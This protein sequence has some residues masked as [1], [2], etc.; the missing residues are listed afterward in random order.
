MA[1]AQIN[2]VVDPEREEDGPRVV[3]P[4]YLPHCEKDGHL[5][6]TTQCEY[7]TPTT[8]F[9][10]QPETG[11]PIS[12]TK[13][14]D[15]IKEY[16]NCDE[17]KYSLNIHTCKERAAAYKIVITMVGGD[18]LPFEYLPVCNNDGSFQA[19]QRNDRFF[20]CVDT[21]NGDKIPK[22]ES[23]R[24]LPITENICKSFSKL[25][26]KFKNNRERDSAYGMMIESKNCSNTRMFDEC[27]CVTTCRMLKMSQLCEG[28]KPICRCPEDSYDLDGTCVDKYECLAVDTEMDNKEKIKRKW[29]LYIEENKDE[30]I[31]LFFNMQESEYYLGVSNIGEYSNQEVLEYA[32]EDGVEYYGYETIFDSKMEEIVE[33]LEMDYDLNKYKKSSM[34]T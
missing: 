17:S 30:N 8:C 1:K 11:L 19:L 29:S 3:D 5:F 9:C 28:C 25:W 26:Q 31:E 33:V 14:Y 20:F 18:K 10:V 16:M 13:R 15:V 32:E 24:E 34:N 23:I 12:G 21:V 22:T 27:G 6:K 2:N 4:L 7:K